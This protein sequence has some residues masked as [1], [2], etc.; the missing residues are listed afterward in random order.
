[1]MKLDEVFVERLLQDC[2]GRTDEHLMERF[3]ISYNTFRKIE[4][5][6]SIRASVALRLMEKLQRETGAQA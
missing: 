5:G 3:G 1:M 4:R 2:P 6:E